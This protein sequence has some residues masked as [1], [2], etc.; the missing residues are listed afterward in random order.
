MKNIREI[1]Q[2]LIDN[3]TLIHK[4]GCKVNIENLDFPNFSN[5]ENW[6]IYDKFADLKKAYAEGA[7]IECS[8]DGKKW[9]KAAPPIWDIGFKYRIK[10]KP[11]MY[12]K[13]K[14]KHEDGVYTTAYLK[15]GG[16]KY[17]KYK[18]LDYTEMEHKTYEE[19]V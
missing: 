6:E 14:R 8:K 16:K 1:Y 17:I 4:Y 18:E 15:V 13:M 10:P 2:A 11:T 3:K 7:I 5:P 19:I 9:D 12:C